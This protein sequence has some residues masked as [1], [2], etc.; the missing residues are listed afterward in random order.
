MVI[1]Q[2][3]EE[4]DEK[5]LPEFIPESE[6]WRDMRVQIIW[7]PKIEPIKQKEEF[8]ETVGTYRTFRSKA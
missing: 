6:R 4:W 7:P 2:W 8:V 5:E 3:W 1:K